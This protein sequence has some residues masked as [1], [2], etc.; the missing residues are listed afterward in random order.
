MQQVIEALPAGERITAVMAMP[1]DEE[2]WPDLSVMFATGKGNVRRNTLA[3]FINIP[4]RGKI[5]MKLD[6]DDVLVGVKPCGPGDHILLA[7]RQGKALRFPAED[8]REF[9]SRA[10]TGVR[11]IAL[12]GDDRVISM[13]VLDGAEFTPEERD[14]YLSQ[15]GIG[16][17]LRT[18]EM[19]GREQMILSVA[20]DGYGKRTSAYDYRVTKRG[21][22]GVEMMARGGEEVEVVAA[23]PVE[24]ADQLLLMTDGGQLIRCP[25]TDIRIAR[26]TTRGV[27]LFDIPEGARVVQVS[28][29]A[30]ADGEDRGEAAGSGADAGNSAGGQE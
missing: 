4:R 30:D 15:N 11:G 17:L 3:D 25:V 13:S 22:Q 26:R 2:R 9:V 29:L 7:T 10:S 19:R 24:A 27:R 5:A 18:T 28:H 6:E 12:R 1:D 16:D 8:V 23:F 14:T 20:S 21:G